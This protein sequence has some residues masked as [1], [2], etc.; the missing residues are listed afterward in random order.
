MNA[1]DI[2]EIRREF[3]PGL[4]NLFAGIVIGLLLIGAGC[5]GLFF[6]AKAVIESRGN[7]PFYVEKGPCWAL[8]ALFSALETAAIVGGVSLIRWI[9]SLSSLR[10]AVGVHGLSVTR[11]DETVA[12]AWADIVSVRET[13]LYER[14]PLLKGVAKYALPK[15]MSKNYRLE[16]NGHEP[17][18]FDGNAIKGHVILAEMIKE[19]TDRRDIPWEIVEEHA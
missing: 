7:L 14:P 4:E 17:F 9:R 16:M 1:Q 18:H 19:D 15:V 5:T 2:G 8:V 12:I 13:R 10:V 11:R 3:K 6:S